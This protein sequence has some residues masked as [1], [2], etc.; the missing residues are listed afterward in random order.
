MPF[1]VMQKN[2]VFILRKTYIIYIDVN[3]EMNNKENKLQNNEKT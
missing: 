1:E 3:S 2:N